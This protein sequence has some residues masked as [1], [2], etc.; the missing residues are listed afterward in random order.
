MRL[1]DAFKEVWSFLKNSFFLSLAFLRVWVEKLRYRNQRTRE[2]S[3]PGSPRLRA[4]QALAGDG[5]VQC[6]FFLKIRW[7][8]PIGGN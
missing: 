6:N 5:A 4:R 2:N 1:E 3:V 7:L 8:I